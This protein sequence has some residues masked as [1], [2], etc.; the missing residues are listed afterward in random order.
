MTAET[1]DEKRKKARAQALQEVAERQGVTGV[2]LGSNAPAH[3]VQRKGPFGAAADLQG[4]SAP[5][6]LPPIT[7][8]AGEPLACNFCYE[9]EKRVEPA[10]TR[11]RSGIPRCA[12][13]ARY[14]E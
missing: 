9:K 1:E 5:P 2:V 12:A 8:A 7:N 10:V 4:G 13:C 14:E 3:I 11:S 6:E